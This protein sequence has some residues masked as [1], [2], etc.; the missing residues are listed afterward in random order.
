MRVPSAPALLLACQLGLVASQ[1]AIHETLQRSLEERTWARNFQRA[2]GGLG[3][4]LSD[5][6]TCGGCMVCLLQRR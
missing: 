5:L 2:D 6:D 4:L 1:E 3:G